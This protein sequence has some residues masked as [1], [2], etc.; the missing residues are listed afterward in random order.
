MAHQN[1]PEASMRDFYNVL[2]RN[3]RKILVFFFSVV[4]VVTL[5]TVLASEVYQ[6]EA[7]LMVRL[8]RESVTLDPTATTGQVVNIGSERENEINSETEILKSRELAE[9]VVDTVGVKLVLEGP[10]ET[11]APGDSLFRIVRYWMR[12]AVKL[13]ADAMAKLLVSNAAPRSAAQLKERDKAVQSLIKHLNIEATKK[14]NIISI[15]YETSDPQL[16][17]DVVD[18]LIGFYLDKHI[19]AHRTTGSYQ[20]FD[21]QKETLQSSL[22][23]TEEKLKNLK[24]RTGT[25][26]ILEQRRILMER[27]GGMQTELQQTESASAA[28]AARVQ[29]LKASLAGLPSTLKTG[30]GT[31]FAMSAADGMR[32]EI[33]EL[34]L[35][36]QELLSTFTAESIPVKEIRRQIR[37]GQALLS[38]AEQ[39]KQVTMGINENYQKIQLDLLTEQSNLSSLQGRAAVLKTQIES[40]RGELSNLNDTEMQL[41]QLE[42]ELETQKSNYRKYSDSLEQARIDQALELEKISNISIVQPASYP[43]KPIRPKKLLNLA[44]GLFLGLFG[45]LGLAFFSEYQDHSFKKPE[46]VDN[47]LH[48]PVLATLPN[49]IHHRKEKSGLKAKRIHRRGAE[50]AEKAKAC[51]MPLWANG[52]GNACRELMHL[53]AGGTLPVPCAVA[54]VGCRSGEG[55]STATGLFA[56]QIALQSGGRVLVVDANS[57]CPS[58]H[59][60][61]GTKLSPGLADFTM[62]GRPSLS[63]IQS[64][65]IEN[66]DL[67]SAGS[68]KLELPAGGLKALA[69]A[70]PSLKREYSHIIVDLP[71]VRDHGPA[72]QI[73][74]LMDGV[75]LVVEAE[76][77]RWEVASR[78]KEDLLQANSKIL[79]VILNKRKMHIPDW[80]Y[81][82]L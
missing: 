30:E 3:K 47:R 78:A 27:I 59:S 72:M 6:S 65:D 36:E 49:A 22:A 21:Q 24:N 74:G 17:R 31:G 70:L 63:C 8:G 51:E 12:R 64:T 58:Q 14:S 19:N 35:K 71:S 2:F 81:K 9:K 29:A 73:A 34:Q 39:T 10:E 82:T 60:I 5:G 67:L 56:R 46:D 15:G 16:A 61:F 79:G 53:F 45:G 50:G 62:N 75:I 20:F 23:Q 42:R 11:L 44:L 77:T 76:S 32:K 48:L 28:S 13:S 40:G 55:V 4:I 69:A 1:Y 26:S 68:G 33:Y 18:K 54:L 57:S 80:L 38:K 66:L 25:A 37:E 52:N 7:E 43:V 41:A